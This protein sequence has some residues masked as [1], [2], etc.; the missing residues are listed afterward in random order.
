MVIP[1]VRFDTTLLQ[2][3]RQS[4]HEWF[5]RQTYSRGD[6]I[7]MGIGDCGPKGQFCRAFLM[8]PYTVEQKAGNT[9][10]HWLVLPPQDLRQEPSLVRPIHIYFCT[11]LVW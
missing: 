9:C 1:F 6:R 8:T 4:G 3:L 5:V 2:A 10:K 7:S 11:M